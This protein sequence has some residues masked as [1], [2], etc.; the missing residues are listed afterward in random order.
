LPFHRI[1]EM[2][3]SGCGKGAATL[4]I[5]GIEIRRLDMPCG[6]LSYCRTTHVLE[7]GK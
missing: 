1:L 6:Q 7:T 4:K 3:S 2:G 5:Y